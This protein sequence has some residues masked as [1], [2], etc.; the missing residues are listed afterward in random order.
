MSAPA[1]VGLIVFVGVP[2]GYAVVLSFY[3]VRLGSP[4]E[5]SFF[6]LEQYR[7]C[8]PTPTCPARSCGPC[9]TT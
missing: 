8:S 4:L 9:S 5:P 6:G 1:V 7:G 3:N 2:F